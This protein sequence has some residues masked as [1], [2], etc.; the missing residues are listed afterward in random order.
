V[1]EIKPN[2]KDL[3]INSSQDFKVTNSLQKLTLEKGP[4]VLPTERE[5]RNKITLSEK[6]IGRVK[7]L[8]NNKKKNNFNSSDKSSTHYFTSTTGGPHNFYSG[9]S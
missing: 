1:A 9:Y 2:K 6:R 5:S 3:K 7:F 4:S 8:E